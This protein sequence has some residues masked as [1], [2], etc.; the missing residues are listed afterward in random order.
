MLLISMVMVRIRIGVSVWLV[1]DYAYLYRPNYLFIL[2]SVVIG[3]FSYLDRSY[4]IDYYNYADW[5][6]V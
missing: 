1:S 2:I 3:P 4:V 6:K 5:C